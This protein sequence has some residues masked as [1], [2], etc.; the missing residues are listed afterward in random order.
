MPLKRSPPIDKDLP[1][2]RRQQL[3]SLKFAR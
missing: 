3:D 2:D 1:K